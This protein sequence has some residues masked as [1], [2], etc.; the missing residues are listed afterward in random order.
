M[1]HYS[2]MKHH[3]TDKSSL[4]YIIN[5]VFFPLKLPQRSDHSLEN[6]LA[7]SQAVLD[8]AFA[9]SDQ[10]SSDK[11]LL[12]TSNLKMLRNFRDS[13]RFSVMSVESQINAMDS[14][15]VLVYMIRAQ[16]AAVVMRNL[17]ARPYSN[18]SKSLPTQPQ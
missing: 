11:L 3:F 4:E 15:D 16:N 8:A 10:L 14:K 17:N 18:H 1:P 12:W 5:H 7:L 2:R 9:F 13:I 6:N